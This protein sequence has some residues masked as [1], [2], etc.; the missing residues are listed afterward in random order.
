MNVFVCCLTQNSSHFGQGDRIFVNL[1]QT[2]DML[3]I[4]AFCMS[5]VDK[6]LDICLDFFSSECYRNCW[7]V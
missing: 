5:E 6:V 1:K 2:T 7:I 3:F 4:S